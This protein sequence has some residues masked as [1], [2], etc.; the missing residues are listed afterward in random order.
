MHFFGSHKIV[1]DLKDDP[2]SLEYRQK[3][4][5]MLDGETASIV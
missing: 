2:I 1:E 4:I 3:I 5:T